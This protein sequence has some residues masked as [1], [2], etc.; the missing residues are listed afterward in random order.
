MAGT[1][2]GG[3]AGLIAERGSGYHP[4]NPHD[5]TPALRALLVALEQWVTDGVAAPA[6]RIPALA[7]GSL[8][9]PEALAFPVIPGVQA[10]CCMNVIAVR[11]DWVHPEPR[12]TA[13]YGARIPQV[14]ADG[15]EIAGI[16]LPPIAVPSATYTGW[17]LYK[18]PYPEGELCDREGS[19]I[20]FAASRADREETGDPRLSLEERYGNRAAYVKQVEEA[21]QALVDAR[22]LLP[23]DAARYIDAAARM[24]FY[25]R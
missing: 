12:P 2:H 18:A 15:N 19:Y 1:Q 9:P 7:D 22:L 23:E 21:A 8:V 10:P 3:R 4:R 14:D 16:R 6:S 20:P 13:V 25:P 24:D 17:N 11:D 5:P